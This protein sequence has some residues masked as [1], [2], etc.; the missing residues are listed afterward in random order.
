MIEDVT[1]VQNIF[2]VIGN[3]MSRSEVIDN[4]ISDGY[5]HNFFFGSDYD[6]IEDD[7]WRVDLKSCSE[8]WMFGEIPVYGNNP[9]FV[10]QR[11]YAND[12]NIEV[13]HMG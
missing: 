10:T 7:N 6:G 13:W 4:L 2:I 9:L 8:L 12:N 3:G 11:K 1:K 5:E